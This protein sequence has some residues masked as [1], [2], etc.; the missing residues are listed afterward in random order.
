MELELKHI[1]PYLP[2]GLKLKDAQGN[3]T[4]LTLGNLNL[5]EM[6]MHWL[7][8]RPLSDMDKI[9]ASVNEPSFKPSS[10]YDLRLYD[11]EWCEEFYAEYGE[12]PK[13]FIPVADMAQ[14]TWPFKYHFDVFGLI[15]AGLA[16]DINTL[17]TPK[18]NQQ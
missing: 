10:R 13:A 8:L 9:I 14:S 15:Q 6:W 16:V 17:T 18:T 11:G 3:V 5:E 2:Y 4:E 1:A 7:V 12:S